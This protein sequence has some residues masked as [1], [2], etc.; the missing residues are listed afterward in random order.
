MYLTPKD[1]YKYLNLNPNPNINPN[2]NNT[3]KELNNKC[4]MDNKY[5]G[6]TPFDINSLLKKNIKEVRKY[7]YNYSVTT[8]ERMI[9]SDT[10]N[11]YVKHDAYE[12]NQDQMGKIQARY[13]SQNDFKGEI[14]DTSKCIFGIIKPEENSPDQKGFLYY[15]DDKEMIG[16]FY[17]NGIPSKMVDILI[18]FEVKCIEDFEE[19]FGNTITPS[20][21]PTEENDRFFEP[22]N[23]T[24]ETPKLHIRLLPHQMYRL[25]SINDV[26]YKTLN[27][28][29][30]VLNVVDPAFYKELTTTLY[31]GNKEGEFMDECEELKIDEAIKGVKM[32]FNKG[33]KNEQYYSLLEYYMT[34]AIMGIM[35]ND[36]ATIEDLIVFVE[37]NLPHGFKWDINGTYYLPG[38]SGNTYLLCWACEYRMVDVVKVCLKYKANPNI[39]NG[40]PLVSVL[41]G[42][43]LQIHSMIRILLLLLSY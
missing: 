32:I 40:I 6:L 13:L 43:P 11:I 8:C 36:P 17:H 15:K 39:D 1:I 37:E 14:F 21:N 29:S 10:S 9:R 33:R 31:R 38:D 35:S 22:K 2:I 7:V 4:E 30:F 25:A 12:I 18:A 5:I 28:S 24:C 16:H 26:G 27:I 41:M 3:P 42:F 20:F 23:F 19:L 34:N